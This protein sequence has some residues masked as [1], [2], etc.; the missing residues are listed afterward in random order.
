MSRFFAGSSPRA[1]QR[2]CPLA[3]EVLQLF[4]IFTEGRRMDLIVTVGDDAASE[5]RPVWPGHQANA[6]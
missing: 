5:V 1:L 3:P 6:H 2:P 4:G